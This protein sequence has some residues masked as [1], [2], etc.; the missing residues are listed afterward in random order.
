[1]FVDTIEEKIHVWVEQRLKELEIG[2]ER[3][4]AAMLLNDAAAQEKAL[5]AGSISANIMPPPTEGAK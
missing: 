3:R 1:M 5:V 2:L 4:F